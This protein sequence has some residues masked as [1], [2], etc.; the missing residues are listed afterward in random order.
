MNNL[1]ASEIKAL[2]KAMNAVLDQRHNVKYGTKVDDALSRAG[3]ILAKALEDND[4]LVRKAFVE[5]RN[6]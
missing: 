4:N 5:A 3:H 2:T 6:G 1:S